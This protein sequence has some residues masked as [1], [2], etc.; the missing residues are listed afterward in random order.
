M[1]FGARF[2]TQAHFCEKRL[3]DA[4]KNLQQKRKRERALMR[5]RDVR[6][7]LLAKCLD[8]SLNQDNEAQCRDDLV[9]T[10]KQSKRFADTGLLSLSP[11]IKRSAWCK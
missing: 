11:D 9:T 10:F 4:W 2:K 7:T 5:S 3:F 6:H 8:F 1:I